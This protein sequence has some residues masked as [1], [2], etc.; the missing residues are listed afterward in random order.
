M[1]LMMQNLASQPN[2]SCNTSTDVVITSGF[3]YLISLAN[4]NNNLNPV[5][6]TDCLQPNL[7]AALLV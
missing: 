7:L 1:I 5:Y 2:M 6:K 4:I 3:L